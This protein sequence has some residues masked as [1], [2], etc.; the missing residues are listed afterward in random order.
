[1]HLIIPFASVLSEAGRHAM[2]DLSLPVLERLLRRLTPVDTCG[3]DEFSW[4]PPHDTALARARGWPTEDGLHPFAATAA[5]ADGLAFGDQPVAL[6]TPAHWM[7]GA[8]QVSLLDPALLA[9]DEAESRE[10][11]EALR[12]LFDEEGW[13]LDWGAALRWY[14]SHPSLGGLATAAPDRVIGRSVDLWLGGGSREPDPRLRKL[15]RLQS[16]V[17]MLLHR[18]PVNE[19]REAR[20]ALA[21]NSFWLSGC[22]SLR[23]FDAAREPV[24]DDRLRHPALH[25][26]WSAWSDAW[27]A[28]DAGPLARFETVLRSGPAA[29][30]LCG[31]RLARRYEPRRD[32][33]WQR[34]RSALGGGP[35]AAAVLAEL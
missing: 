29:L 20:G 5:A 10:L 12:P 31:E 2:A 17:Q 4:S 25:D 33:A 22:G 27:R 7:V 9:L 15:R 35:D 14:A 30:T 16:E 11:L 26:D 13:Q 32:S 28:L 19:A 24:V 8:D 1:M 18:H 34:L 6:L 23:P 3:S 21:V